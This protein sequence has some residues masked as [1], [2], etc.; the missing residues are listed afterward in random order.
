[1]EVVR[2][3]TTLLI[4]DDSCTWS[5]DQ[6]TGRNQLVTRRPLTT[7]IAIFFCFSLYFEF[8]VH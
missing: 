7:A 1:M 6:A 3:P 2:H 4:S 8:G 5:T